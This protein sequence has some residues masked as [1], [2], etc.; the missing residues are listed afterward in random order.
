MTFPIFEPHQQIGAF[1]IVS[2]QRIEDL[3]CQLTIARHGESGARVLHMGNDDPENLFCL[4]FSTPALDA[5]GISHILEHCVLC[6]SEKYGVK[7]PF[8]SMARRS[9]NTF[10]NAFTGSDFTCYPAASQVRSDFF[11]LLKV[12]LDAVFHPRLSELSFLQE[13]I[14]RFIDSEGNVQFKGIVYNEMKG[15][16]ALPEKRLW[17]HLLARLLPHTSFGHDSGGDPKCIPNLTIQSLRRYHSRFYHPSRCLFYFYGNIPLQE[18][19]QFLHDG[20]LSKA[21]CAPQLPKE[22]IQLRRSKPNYLTRSY[23]ADDDSD[24]HRPLFG[25]SWW[26]GDLTALD[27]LFIISLLDELMMGSDGAPLK[28]QLIEQKICQ[29]VQSS[30]ETESPQTAYLLILKGCSSTSGSALTKQVMKILIKI[31]KGGFDE[32]QVQAAIH[33]MELQHLEIDSGQYPYGLALFWRA[34]LSSLHGADPHSALLVSSQLQALKQLAA[35]SDV[36][37]SHFYRL[38]IDNQHRSSVSLRPDP[39]LTRGEQIDEKKRLALIK[40]KLTPFQKKRIEQQ[41]IALKTAQEQRE[42]LS[43]LPILPID[44]VGSKPQ[45]FSLTSYPLH[46]G[47]CHYHKVHTNGFV[48]IDCLIPL[49]N[50]NE[51]FSLDPKKIPLAALW[52]IFANFLPLMGTSRRSF[53]Q[54]SELIAAHSGGISA[55]ITCFSNAFEERFSSHLHLR[56]KGLKRKL[57][58]L[59]GLLSDIMTDAQFQ[60]TGRLK[61]LMAQQSLSLE[62]NLTRNA[63]SY[64][65]HAASCFHSKLARYLDCH[66]GFGYLKAMRSLF[67][68]VRGDSKDLESALLRP[69]CHLQANLPSPEHLIITCEEREWDAMVAE[70]FYGFQEHFRSAPALQRAEKSQFDQKPYRR[71]MGFPIQAQVATNAFALPGVG[72]ADKDFAK[73]QLLSQLL[74]HNTLH[75]QIREKGGA[76]GSGALCRSDWQALVLYSA[77]DPNVAATKAVFVQALRDSSSK[78][79]SDQELD[80]AKRAVIQQLDSPIQPGD[81][82]IT[83]FGWKMQEKNLAVRTEHRKRLL[84]ATADEIRSCCERCLIP[85]V[86]DASFASASGKEHLLKENPELSI[87]QM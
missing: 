41:T 54:N 69:L 38:L 67:Q 76:Y 17:S 81:R 84:N 3:K 86:N 21:L 30:L 18:H 57:P 37:K 87:C 24:V 35:S 43:C 20:V 71:E 74:Q 27:D 22:R 55:N 61:E 60:D 53:A 39:D 1:Q 44:A 49:P 33:R 62:Q 58:Q 63:T 11:N 7:D 19:L 70:Q 80:E 50:W 68:K 4:A 45:D 56:I 16:Y 40:S 5:T 6:G 2:S 48:Y 34:G 14:R 46:Q 73:L 79:C 26:T 15:A 9:L 47:T 32:D 77:Q 28:C 8:F 31:A 78:N 66:L 51:V 64:A 42:D 13:G 83:A 12:Y 65:I 23:P 10:M 36:L 29:Q 85:F 82:G 72:Y 59:F 25:I 52:R 75:P